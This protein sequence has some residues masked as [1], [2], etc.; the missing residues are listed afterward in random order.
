VGGAHHR[1]L[2]ILRPLT[3][4]H[5]GDGRLVL[6]R[7]AVEG[8]EM[9]EHALPVITIRRGKTRRRSTAELCRCEDIPGT[10]RMFSVS[11][12]VRFVLGETYC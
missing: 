11:Y 1:H 8:P 4:D 10:G 5:M 2:P 9:S 7:G 12:G 3:G 6:P